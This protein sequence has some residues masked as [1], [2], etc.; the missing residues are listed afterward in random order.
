[1]AASVGRMLLQ[2]VAGG[3]G[4]DADVLITGAAAQDAIER[5]IDL[6]V[7]SFGLGSQQFMKRD[8]EPGCAKSALE[9][10]MVVESL[11]QGV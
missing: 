2:A 10:V 6:G 5:L 8:Q 7:G 3:L 9:R 11:L 4:S 1:M